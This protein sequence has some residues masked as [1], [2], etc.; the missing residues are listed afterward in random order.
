MTLEKIVLF[1]TIIGCVLGSIALDLN[2]F[3]KYKVA[4]HCLMAISGVL[5]CKLFE[6]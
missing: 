4:S 1:L 3:D 2:D 5:I 6:L